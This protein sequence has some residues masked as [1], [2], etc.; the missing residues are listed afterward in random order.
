MGN[1]VID[2]QK[3][4]DLIRARERLGLGSTAL[5]YRIGVAKSTVS[6]IEAGIS[7]PSLALMQKWVKAL[8]GATMEMFAAPSAKARPS[9]PGPRAARD[10]AA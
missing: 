7:H 10:A 9:R 5:A 3:R 6:R 4:T 8:P 2:P 1:K